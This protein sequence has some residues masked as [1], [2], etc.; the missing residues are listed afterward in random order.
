MSDF[1]TDL[2]VALASNQLVLI[3]EFTLQ[4]QHL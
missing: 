2:A 4:V 1:T 3:L